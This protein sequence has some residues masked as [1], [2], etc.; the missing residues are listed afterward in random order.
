V[1]RPAG[2]GTSPGQAR[3][4]PGPR[5]GVYRRRRLAAAALGALVLLVAL[6]LGGRLLVYEAGLADVEGVT[7]TGALAVPV[8]DVV[9]AAAVPTGVPLAAVDTGAVAARVAEL[10]GVA[11]AEVRR[12]WPHTV[13]VEVTERVPVLTAATPG[14]LRL[15]DAAGVP[16][17]GAA[18]RFD[19][20]R[21]RAPA[22]GP[23][24]PATVA[25]LEVLAALDGAV[26]A[27]VDVVEV[28]ATGQ[29]TLE[30]ADDR[31]VRWGDASRTPEKA[32]VLGPLL[33]QSGRVYDVASPD[34]PT[35]RR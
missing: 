28:T 16:Y 32:A 9:A 23:G 1:T 4:R 5:P 10:P 17:A 24:E 19:L 6:G 29:I 35:I 18:E 33:G 26:R 27:E 31:E 21:L 30:L 25:A 34:L 2:T 11:G 8:A 7:V 15:V 3:S 14:G 20:P 13:T 22:V 12:D